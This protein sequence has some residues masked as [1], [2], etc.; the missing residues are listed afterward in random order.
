MGEKR[1][2]G[3]T[4]KGGPRPQQGK[5]GSRNGSPTGKP[6]PRPRPTGK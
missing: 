2:G 1:K 6:T 5:G 3:N 4:N